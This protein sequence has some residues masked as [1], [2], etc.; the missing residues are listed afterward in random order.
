MSFCQIC[1]KSCLFYSLFI[2][3]FKL[4]N[5]YIIF[6]NEKNCLISCIIKFKYLF[7]SFLH[8]NEC[9]QFEEEKK[10]CTKQSIFIFANEL[11]NAKNFN[12]NQH[13]FLYAIFHCFVRHDRW[14][15]SEEQLG[16]LFT[17]NCWNVTCWMVFDD[18]L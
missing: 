6:F 16:M 13:V 12:S 9:F 17:E 11:R 4:V 2:L 7:F 3:L 15:C 14:T 18:H 10:N 8:E 5:S 1:I